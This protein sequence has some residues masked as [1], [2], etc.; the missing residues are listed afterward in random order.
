MDAN[1]FAMNYYRLPSPERAPDALATVAQQSLPRNDAEAAVWAYIFTKIGT[2]SPEVIPAYR[3]IA[4]RTNDPLVGAVL[5]RAE[6][7]AEYAPHLAPV[8]APIDIDFLWAEFGLTGAAAPVRRVI[9]IFDWPQFLRPRLERWLVGAPSGERVALCARLAESGIICDADA[10][11]IISHDDSDALA[12]VDEWGLNA[13]AEQFKRFV[14]AMPWPLTS[15]DIAYLL[16][17]GNARWTL[18]LNASQHDVV[19]EISQAELK[20]ATWLTKLA[21]LD[22]ISAAL[23]VRRDYEAASAQIRQYL[24]IDPSRVSMKRRLLFAEHGGNP[25]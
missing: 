22:A 18:A 12:V 2:D 7:H 5:E 25:P 8:E 24:A 9:G 21:L 1:H 19:L 6:R 16:L 4:Q 10:K 11:E 14:E 23:L 13:P 15:P 20:S 17:K 3:E